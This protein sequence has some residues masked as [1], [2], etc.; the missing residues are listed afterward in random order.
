MSQAEIRVG[1]QVVCIADNW[2]R[3]HGIEVCPYKGQVLTVRDFDRE[4]KSKVGLLFNEIVNPAL[5]YI[6]G[7]KEPAFDSVHFRPCRKT[8]ISVFKHNLVPM[9]DEV[10]V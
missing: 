8:D 4:F 10:L 2:F 3:L 5:D 9:R 1:T 6:N 7:R